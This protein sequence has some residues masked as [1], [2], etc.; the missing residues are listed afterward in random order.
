[1]KF[2]T[3]I[4]RDEGIISYS[5]NQV[6]KISDRYKKEGLVSARCKSL[7]LFKEKDTETF[8]YRFSPNR[9]IFLKLKSEW[10]NVHSRGSS[11]NEIFLLTFYCYSR[12]E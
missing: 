10:R 8:K 1:M 9:I 2:Y 11:S 3:I 5:F 6:I 7:T 4:N 12:R